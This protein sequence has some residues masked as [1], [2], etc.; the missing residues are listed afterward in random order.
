MTSQKTVEDLEKA[1]GTKSY[2][3]IPFSEN[4]DVLIPRWIALWIVQAYQTA[5]HL[6]L[7]P[8][9]PFTFDE[10]TGVVLAKDLP[11]AEV[12]KITGVP[13]RVILELNPKVKPSAGMFV[14][15]SHGKRTV[16]TIAAP[17][18]KGRLLVRELKKR[19]FLAT[20]GK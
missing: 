16:H 4:A 13:S 8:P 5:Y 3:D 7:K 9:R 1:W 14:A 18:G 10:V 17:R 19:G 15:K 12:A 20:A 6:H 2:W 11:V